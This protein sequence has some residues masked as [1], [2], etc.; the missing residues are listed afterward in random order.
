MA[1][2]RLGRIE[3]LED[4]A[5][6]GSLLGR[7]DDVGAIAGRKAQDRLVAGIDEVVTALATGV[8]LAARTGVDD[9]G[10]VGLLRGDQ[11]S[12]DLI[13][14]DGGAVGKDE[15]F[16]P[17]G[18]DVAERAPVDDQS[19]ARTLEPDEQVTILV[20]EPN[21]AGVDGGAEENPV[22]AGGVA[23]RIIA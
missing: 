9:V 7:I 22:D 19:V 18:V 8:D 4:Q 10:A 2:D 12:P 21:H 15:G 13:H 14:G 20:G 17:S 23:N 1:Y 3:I 16:N 11:K 5:A 6:A